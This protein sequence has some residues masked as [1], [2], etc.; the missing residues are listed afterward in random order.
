ME[1]D[2]WNTEPKTGNNHQQQGKMT[3][4][5]EAYYTCP[6]HEKSGLLAIYCLAT[7]PLT[8][9]HSHIHE[10]GLL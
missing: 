1:Y 2:R 9:N 6:L 4:V 10:T 8:E 5:V 7:S 3:R